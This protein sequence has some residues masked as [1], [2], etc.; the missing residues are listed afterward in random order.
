M[1]RTGLLVAVFGLIALCTAY[2]EGALAEWGPLH[3]QE[4]LGGGQGIAA[5]GYAAVAL[6]MALGRLSGT[7]LL[8][9]LGQ[10][11]A[12][13]LGG[14][15]AAAGMLLG[16]L[17]PSVWLALAG[18]AVTG[19]GLANLFPVAIARA[20]ELA[21]PS[22]VAAASTLGYGGML[23]GPPSIGFLA[24]AF[25]LPTALTT[26]ALLAATASA[27]AYAVRNLGTRTGP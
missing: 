5:A 10:T 25:G 22:G 21:G 8:E 12:L 13:V 26:V 18:F 3:I 19:L 17:A 11:R 1:H 6:A 24:D 7:A 20:G 27:I 2:G 16:A 14:L 9:R 4:D 15:T 23:L